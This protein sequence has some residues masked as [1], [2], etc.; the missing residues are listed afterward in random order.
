MAAAQATA[1]PEA[2]ANN[3]NVAPSPH[4]RQTETDSLTGTLSESSSRYGDIDIDE[5]PSLLDKNGISR[6]FIDAVRYSEA[7]ASDDRS[8]ESSEHSTAWTRSS[9]TSDAGSNV[10]PVR[11]FA[12]LVGR[13][14]SHPDLAASERF[15]KITVNSSLNED[16]VLGSP[17][18]H[19]QLELDE[20]ELPPA[21]VV[22]RTGRL[23]E[24]RS[25]EAEA[26]RPLSARSSSVS[27]LT[28][29]EIVRLLVEEF[30]PLTTSDDDKEELVFEVDGAYFQE[31]AILGMVHL[32]THRLSFHA[33]L[34][35]TRPDLL[36]GKQIIRTGPATIHYLGLRR[37]RRLWLELSH[38]MFT[39]FPSGNEED[40]IRPIRSVLLSSIKQIL[41]ED[42][43]NKKIIR[44]IS[45]SH[46]TEDKYVEFDTEE[47]A[48]DW[49][50]ELQGAMY[51]Y[52]HRRAAYLNSQSEDESNGVRISIPLSRIKSH[53]T[54]KFMKFAYMLSIELGSAKAYSGPRGSSDNTSNEDEGSESSPR[55]S[56]DEEMDIDGRTLV[57]AA[58]QRLHA[59]ED[60]GERVEKAKERERKASTRVSPKVIVDFGVLSFVEQRRESRKVEDDKEEAIRN[61]LSL[62]SEGEKVWYARSRIAGSIASSGYFAITSRYIGF[63]TKCFSV[64]DAKY[65]YPISKVAGARV[66]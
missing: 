34:L 9:R 38:D 39:T 45:A 62:G 5:R 25:D 42:P 33:S 24:L 7:I 29:D 18:K 66:A 65:R 12:D 64:S 35:S 54:R 63:W 60:F 55:T 19:E 61:A 47:S 26:A 44:I 27:Q 3:S 15:A 48:R 21:K 56:E 36:P 17:E 23:A 32:T 28:S 31:I 51:L 4:R 30:G 1:D 20:A 13:D 41:P 57:I 52:R 59:W 43:D 46:D 40:R 16:T 49:R 58:T 50:R 8:E 37:K 14:L 10:D 2:A 11:R 6:I 22:E 53:S